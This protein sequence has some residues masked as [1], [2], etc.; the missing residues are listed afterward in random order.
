M[1]F[2]N[3]GAHFL[4]NESTVMDSWFQVCMCVLSGEAQISKYVSHLSSFLLL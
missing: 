1:R 2:H 3:S 4:S